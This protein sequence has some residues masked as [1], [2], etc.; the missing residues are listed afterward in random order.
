MP[1][2]AEKKAK[3]QG[4]IKRW[5]IIKR[6]GKTMRCMITKKKGP[7]GGSTVCYRIKKKKK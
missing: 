1:K 4:G 3:K 5:R 2:W 7:R 6:G